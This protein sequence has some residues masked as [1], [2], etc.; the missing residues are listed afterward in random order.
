MKNGKCVFF[1]LKIDFGD[2]NI[3]QK[4][5]ENFF[6]F[7]F[8][9][10]ALLCVWLWLL[11]GGALCIHPCAVI[12]Q[13]AASITID[14][15][16]APFPR[17]EWL[18]WSFFPCLFTQKGYIFHDPPALRKEDVAGCNGIAV[19][20]LCTQITLIPRSGLPVG[21]DG[22]GG[23]KPLGNSKFCGFCA[24]L[25]GRDVPWPKGTWSKVWTDKKENFNFSEL[26]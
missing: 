22:W 2:L 24:F 9:T 1:V 15:I 18:S 21:S 14:I 4:V 5:L 19:C 26:R 16:T 6:T 25:W 11:R 3:V 10:N 8:K 13:E 20:L 12:P 17:K 23:R 7:L